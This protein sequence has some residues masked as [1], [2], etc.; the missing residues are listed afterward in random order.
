MKEGFDSTAFNEQAITPKKSKIWVWVFMFGVVLAILIIGGYFVYFNSPGEPQLVK[1]NSLEIVNV[2]RNCEK[3]GADY[4]D[5]TLQTTI[6]VEI[7]KNEKYS[8]K[9][10]EYKQSY[11]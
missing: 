9:T 11:N 3:N 4:K 5:T 7:T 10:G 8:E 2:Y 1:I 6:D